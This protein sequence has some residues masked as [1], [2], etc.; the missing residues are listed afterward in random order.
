[1]ENIKV[2]VASAS[3]AADHDRLI[4]AILDELSVD[5]IGWRDLVG[6]GEI[7]IDGLI[8]SCSQADAAI[9]IASPDDFTTTRGRDEMSPRDNIL[10][11]IGMCLT[12]LG[13]DRVLIAHFAD[14]KG[15]HPKLP[16]DLQGLFVLRCH[17]S[18]KNKLEYE[19]HEWIHGLT[20]RTTKERVAL[21]KAITEIDA[22]TEKLNKND[23][24]IIK[25]YV[26]NRFVHDVSNLQG[27]ELILSQTEYFSQLNREIDTAAE[28]SELIAIATM[29][30]NM[31]DR[32]PEQTIYATKNLEASKRKV[33]IKRLF[34]CSDKDWNDVY[35]NVEKQL[36]AGI[37]VRRISPSVM[38]DIKHLVDVAIFRSPNDT[39]RG[40]IAEKDIHNLSRIR[41]GRIV[42]NMRSDHPTLEAFDRAWS[43]A[44]SAKVAE[45]PMALV[46]NTVDPPGA[47]MEILNLDTNVVS[48]D[49]AASAK[50][51]PLKNELKSIILATSDG[52]VALHL[53]GDRRVS[54]RAVKNTLDVKQ[55][56]MLP[57]SELEK[58]GLVAGTVSAVLEP[59]WSMPHLISRS[60]LALEYV[61]TNA[62]V[63]DQYFKF[64][65][66]ILLQAKSTF[67]GDFEED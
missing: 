2:F 30:A 14:E 39:A 24:E 6:P 56:Y 34:I 33:K 38:R 3:E 12:G 4:R 53:R 5:V 48:C 50:G 18:K 13:R 42:F 67:I 20:T 19:V 16:T 47:S 28:G 61:S 10:L 52:M 21:E 22:F 11:E 23:R 59:V 43:L 63:L 65:P 49:Q 37:E 35:D 44:S 31:W 66:E 64:K 25:K 1:M 40:Y 17:P 41:R 57:A 29:S 51:I 26:V 32:D 15:K 7:F 46:A 9:L 45:T 60:V 8:E 55:A 27:N 54:L 62:R 36:D 58:I